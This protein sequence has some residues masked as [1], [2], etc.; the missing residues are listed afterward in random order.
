MF[1]G[2][3]SFRHCLNRGL[4]LSTVLFDSRCCI[5]PLQGGTLLMTERGSKNMSLVNTY[6][7]GMYRQRCVKEKKKQAKNPTSIDSS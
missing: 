5:Y 7:H 3:L 6:I 4:E 2:M 1:L